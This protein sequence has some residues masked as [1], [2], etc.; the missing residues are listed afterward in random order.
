MDEH[1]PTFLIVYLHPE[2]EGAALYLIA[3]ALT[4]AGIASRLIAKPRERVSLA[5]PNGRNVFDYREESR[6]LFFVGRTGGGELTRFNKRHQQCD[7]LPCICSRPRC[8][9]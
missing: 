4:A 8:G 3:E 9:S 2:H 7:I 5:T 6:P 1:T